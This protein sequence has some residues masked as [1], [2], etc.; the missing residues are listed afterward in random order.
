M[1][2]NE[3][4]ISLCLSGGGFRAT[5]FHL[6]LIRYLY[7][8]GLLRHVNR[9]FSVSGGSILAAHLVQNWHLYTGN[10][11]E[12]TTCAEELLAFGQLDVRGRV[13]RRWLLSI[14]LFPLRLLPGK[15]WKRTLLLQRYY[16]QHLYKNGDLKSL[17]NRKSGLIPP[18]VHILS[19]SLTT[20]LLCSFN[21]IGF[22]SD[23]GGEPNFIRAGLLPLSMAV[24]A[25]SA[26][27]PLFPPVELTRGSLDALEG[28]LQYDREMLSDGGVFDNLGIRKFLRMTNINADPSSVIIVSDAG[29]GF[30][31]Q[32]GRKFGNIATRTARATDILMKRVSDFER[33]SLNFEPD[34]KNI[35]VVKCSIGTVVTDDRK[36][37]ILDEDV[38]ER[39]GRIRTDL[40][41]FLDIELNVLVRHGYEVSAKALSEKSSWF[42][43]SAN[44]SPESDE[45]WTPRPTKKAPSVATVAKVLEE[46]RS[47]KPGIW[48][49]RDWASWVL[50]A[51]SFL[52]P[53]T[54]VTSL[55]LN[56]AFVAHARSGI[57][58]IFYA[59]NR[60]TDDT[61]STT[62]SSKLET[63]PIHVGSVDVSIPA[64][65]KIG[66]IESPSFLSFQFNNDPAQYVTMVSIHASLHEPFF[67]EL[68]S[69]VTGANG[70]LL[71]LVNG[72]NTDFKYG[73]RSDATLAYDLNLAAPAIDLSW[74]SGS[75][76]QYW[77]AEEV[78]EASTVAF[79]DFVKIVCQKTDVKRINIIARS[80]GARLVMQILQDLHRSQEGAHVKVGEVMLLYPDVSVVL[81]EATAPDL[82]NTASRITVYRSDNQQMR[83]AK[84]VQSSAR[85]GDPKS[86]M[87]LPE[88]IDVIDVPDDAAKSPLI[89]DMFQ[90]L[91]GSQPLDRPNL[92]RVVADGQT[93]YILGN[94]K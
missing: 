11:A 57:V 22:W 44:H 90:V 31:Y 30:D 2:D 68:K 42:G 49:P 8:T 74:P 21:K 41:R 89:A 66:D 72:A 70:D 15:F 50:V 39:I 33:D 24:A 93:R 29:A 1:E 37:T 43:L 71:L 25:S 79:S 92:R 55:A 48:N 40:D 27:P 20:G 62:F 64:S 28:K 46:S 9:I 26:F 77:G 80:M 63:G 61:L 7:E 67:D 65:H 56:V 54:V 16:A 47:Q 73:T 53:A 14:L 35:K 91:R 84:V 45:A 69:A 36:S 19:T 87:H 12:F 23:D 51:S 10:E 5:F 17:G 85:V 38:Q 60:A 94:S 59:T 3:L 82:V 76:T 4:R 6:G 75:L 18:E 58:R 32:I 81:F 13:V 52:I 86:I 78:S 34:G 83:L 88:Q